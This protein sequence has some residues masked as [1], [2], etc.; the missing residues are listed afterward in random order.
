MS[1]D[2]RLRHCYWVWRVNHDK[3]A[4]VS[5]LRKFSQKENED[6]DQSIF[7]LG[8]GCPEP[9]VEKYPV[10]LVPLTNAEREK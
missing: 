6:K 1:K 9:E 2:N 3:V 10:L 5:L 7:D 8:W 4:H